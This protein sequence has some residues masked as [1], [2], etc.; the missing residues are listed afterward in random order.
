MTVSKL[1]FNIIYIYYSDQQMHNKYINNIIYI[2]CAFAGLYNEL[3]KV[4]GT[5]TKIEAIDITIYIYIYI[6]CCW[7]FLG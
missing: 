1:L 2:C 6:L 3:Y 7:H 5:Y 4:N